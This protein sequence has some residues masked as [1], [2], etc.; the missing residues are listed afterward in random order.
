[1]TDRELKTQVR[2]V[3]DA[4][5]PPL[6]DDPELAEKVL[7]RHEEKQQ[8][9]R[10][11]RI[12]LRYAAALAV[13][14]LVVCG[15]AILQSLPRGYVEA[16]LSADGEQYIMTGVTVT[17]PV[18]QAA[19]AATYSA[20]EWFELT[21]EDDDEAMEA[22]GEGT[23]LPVWLP[24]GWAADQYHIVNSSTLKR[25]SVHYTHDPSGDEEPGY[26]VYAVTAFSSLEDFHLSAEVNGEG[27]NVKLKNGLSI[28]VDMN[29]NRIT[30][31]WQDGLTGYSLSGDI[32]EDE[33]LHIIRSMYGLD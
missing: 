30:S 16:S 14:V 7:E 2:Q 13:M 24:D 9:R 22:L 29:V 1:M 20:S 8:K 19:N 23:M 15:E 26:L 5:M 27:R 25:V 18:G 3:L 28:Y 11:R 17:P 6:P 4:S 31:M 32:T 21:T 33:L 12:G 10:G